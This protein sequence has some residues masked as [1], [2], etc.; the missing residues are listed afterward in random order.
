MIAFAAQEQ[1]TSR[2]RDGSGDDQG[3]QILPFLA[4]YIDVS[5]HQEKMATP[6]AIISG[7]MHL[8]QTIFIMW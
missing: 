2:I 5:P 6:I 3:K 1:M 4:L 7:S 8:A